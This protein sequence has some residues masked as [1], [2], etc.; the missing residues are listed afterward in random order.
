[1]LKFSHLSEHGIAGKGELEFPVGKGMSH[2]QG[3]DSQEQGTEQDRQHMRQA[4]ELASRG[5]GHTSPNPVV[6]SVVVRRDTVVGRGYHQKAG[7]P[8]AEINALR[9]AG[10]EA[11]GST[12]YVTLEPCNHFGRTPPCTH[13]ILDAG[14]S[15]V[16]MGM[17][18]PNP[19]VEGGGASFLEKNGV[20]ITRRVLEKECRQQNQAFIK[21]SISG[22][23]HVT[24]KAAATLDGRIATRTGDSRWITNEESRS[25]V[26]ELRAELDAILVGIGTVLA[27]DPQ[28]TA[29]L[30]SEFPIPQPVRVVVDSRLQIPLQSRL[31]QTARDVPLWIACG[32]DA[33]LDREEPLLERGAQVLRLPLT[34]N[35]VHLKSLLKELGKLPLTSVLVE[36]GAQILGA[37][38]EEGLADAFHF[39]FAPKILGDPKGIPMIRGKLREKMAEAIP[40]HGMRVRCFGEDVMLSGRFQ[41]NLY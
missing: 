7:G 14:I 15:R 23:P 21:H 36:G 27:D 6:G 28:L 12:L 25:F 1:M 41:E 2:S 8:H 19:K 5:S 38:I 10:R 29:R 18:D 39:F 13:A 35:H 31:I 17:M 24:L 9:D 3:I 30:P 20:S 33:P 32:E 4:L 22:L 37:F 34:D 40:T 11:V 26:H 16:V